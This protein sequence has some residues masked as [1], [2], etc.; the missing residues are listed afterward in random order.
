MQAG[1]RAGGGLRAGAPPAHA[2]ARRRHAGMKSSE[3][4]VKSSSSPGGPIACIYSQLARWLQG[5]SLRAAACQWRICA[6]FACMGRNGQKFNSAASDSLLCTNVGRLL[7]PEPACARVAGRCR[8][9][10][11]QRC[12][13]MRLIKSALAQTAVWG[14]LYQSACT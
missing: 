12:A 5:A 8:P 3:H 6:R 9:G 10:Q 13:P 1:V 14:S 7:E 2:P 11:A 4:V